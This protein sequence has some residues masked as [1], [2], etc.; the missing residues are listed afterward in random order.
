MWIL[1]ASRP[2]NPNAGRGADAE[3][4]G[5]IV[6][7]GFVLLGPSRALA[8]ECGGRA[9]GLCR[10]IERFRPERFSGSIGGSRIMSPTWAR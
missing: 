1:F 5:V 8:R 10:P 4:E 6:N 7:F 9:D 2:L 3:R